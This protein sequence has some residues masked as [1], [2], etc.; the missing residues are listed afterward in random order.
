MLTAPSRRPLV[1]PL[2]SRL[3]P[4]GAL[5][6][7]AIGVLVLGWLI[8]HGHAGLAATAIV[9][10][11]ALG[12]IV[13]SPVRG[14]ALALAMVVLVPPTTTFGFA[15]L[16]LMRLVAMLVLLALFLDL[17]T[18]PRVSRLT[19]VDWAV[20][21]LLVLT[22]LSWA[23]RPREAHSL[24]LVSNYLLPLAFFAGG[25]RFGE[26]NVRRLYAFLFVGAAL[27][28]LSVLYE[29][30]LAHRPLFT[31]PT[32][33]YWLASSNNIF[34]PGGVFGSPPAAAAV[35][36]M[37]IPCGVALVQR[38]TGPR[39]LALMALLAVSLAALV[40]TFT[41]GPEIGLA[42][43][44][45]AYAALLGPATWARYAYAVA[46]GAIV[47]TV[48]L[49]PQIEST[50][51][52]QHG[53]LRHGTLASRETFWAEAKFVIRDS[54][55]H[56]IV[57]HG[58]DSLIVGL[59]WAPGDPQSDISRFPDL[60]FQGL[61][62]Q[63]LRMLVEAGAVGLALFLVWIGGAILK[64][65]R[66][67]FRDVP[68]RREIAAG[69]AGCVAFCVTSLVGDTLREP[70]VFVVAALLSGIVVSLASQA[71]GDEVEA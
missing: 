38:A 18:S 40:V 55:Q 64:G 71:A 16:G 19:L 42:V 45:V 4:L 43:G 20:V 3:L 47:A 68:R 31:D 8:S 62:N 46:I 22:L 61:Q 14:L 58:P 32:S 6:C 5:A 24:R 54:T 10:A 11:P 12:Y 7:G 52:F 66:A 33:Y 28:S 15:Q 2:V 9:A 44:M 13:G 1:E 39:R 21:G 59:P 63:Y 36:A 30:F 17:R 67:A 56:E 49:L 41:R 70:Q 48:V 65:T 29:A 69:V 57:G 51:W 27:A 25:R 60:T 34:R 35:L 53:V 26:R 23:L 50:S 37:A